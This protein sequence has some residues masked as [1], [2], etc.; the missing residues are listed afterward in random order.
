V[1]DGLLATEP[2]GYVLRVASDLFDACVMGRLSTLIIAMI[3]VAAACTGSGATDPSSPATTPTPSPSVATAPTPTPSATPKAFTAAV[4]FD[5]QVCTYSGPL[6]LPRASLLTVMLT[7][8]PDAL[9]G[10]SG[11]ALVVLHVQ[12]G[13]T[14]DRILHDV[15]EVPADSDLL[16]EWVDPTSIYYLY[17]WQAA[18]GGLV[19]MLVHDRYLVGCATAPED[20]NRVYPATLIQTLEG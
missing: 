11:A 12:P 14:W 10:S 15:D 20:T 6:V 2:T 16:P 8:T 19:A 4:A 7:N 9:K 17:P 1:T 18:T 13:T 5:G 3:L